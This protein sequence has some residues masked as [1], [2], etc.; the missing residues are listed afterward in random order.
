MIVERGE[1]CD[2]CPVHGRRGHGMRSPAQPQGRSQE[3][4]DGAPE[5]CRAWAHLQRSGT[6]QPPPR[7]RLPSLCGQ[8]RLTTATQGSQ[9]PASLSPQQLRPVR[10][11][12]LQR[13]ECA[14]GQT[15]SRTRQACKHDGRESSL[16]AAG[17][18]APS[19]KEPRRFRPELA[20]QRLA[21][22]HPPRSVAAE[23][24]LALCHEAVAQT[25]QKPSASIGQR[26]NT[27]R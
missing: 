22:K 21:S 3:S 11:A 8:N 1:A 18:A 13:A 24:G 19:L 4:S 27:C 16:S 6:H 17:A 14:S 15:V 25:T 26:D 5:G 2:D 9:T 10:S 20:A 7:T 23:G 12:H